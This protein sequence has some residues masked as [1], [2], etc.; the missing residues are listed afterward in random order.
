VLRHYLS[1]LFKISLAKVISNSGVALFFIV[2]ASQEIT[3]MLSFVYPFVG[4]T[5]PKEAISLREE[6]LGQVEDNR[7]PNIGQCVG[8]IM[9]CSVMLNSIFFSFARFWHYILI[10]FQVLV[11]ST[12]GLYHILYDNLDFYMPFLLPTSNIRALFTTQ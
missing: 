2:L 1:Y 5:L 12:D 4:S 9:S 8:I 6:P 10:F 7:I 3:S 11:C